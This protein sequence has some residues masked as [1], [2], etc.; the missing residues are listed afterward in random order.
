MAKRKDIRSKAQYNQAFEL[1]KDGKEND[2][3]KAYQ[4]AA[5][6]DPTN[7]LAWN[8][9]MMIYRKSKTRPQEIALIKT[10]ISSYKSS[11]ATTHQNWL[12]ANSQKAK[13]T[14]ELATVLG[15]IE[16]DGLPKTEHAILEK[17]ETRL[18]LLE[19][20]ENNAKRKK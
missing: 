10:A 11:V 1:E 9:Q 16:P 2:A 12:K 5:T 20:R 18:Y 4:K 14:S 3:L 7:T 19:Y 6:T 15:M 8:R 13:N 17:W